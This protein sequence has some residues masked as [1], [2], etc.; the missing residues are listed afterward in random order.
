MP[1]GTIYAAALGGSIANR[2]APVSLG[3]ASAMSVTVTAPA[4]SITVSDTADSNAQA[5]PDIKPKVDTSK[6]PAGQQAQAASVS[7][8]TEIPGVEKSAVYRIRPDATVETVWSSK[9]ENAYGLVVEPAGTVVVATDGQGR[10]YRLG[11]D[12]KATMLVETN[13]GETTRLIRDSSGLV[14]ATG[15]MGKLFRLGGAEGGGGTYESPVHDAGAA[16]RWG[17]ISWRSAGGKV[18]L[19][20]RSGNSARPDKTWSD[21]SAALTDPQGSM[22]PSPNARYI[23]WRASL[24]GSGATAENVRVFYLP[25][26]NPPSVR[27]INVSTQAPG[28]NAQKTTG[29]SSS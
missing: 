3:A 22:I 8:L 9:D 16:S 15:D 23:Q 27:S 25:Q 2:S 20:T 24:N 19:S 5:G 6:A 11:Q 1:D 10:V 12:R 18:T 7:P 4:T 26:N 14:A 13:E 28:A 21:W 29:N 17:R